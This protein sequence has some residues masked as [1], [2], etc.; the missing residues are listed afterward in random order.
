M[1]HYH[2]T[3]QA[4]DNAIGDMMIGTAPISLIADD[5]ES[6][7]KRAREILKRPH[8]RTAGVVECFD[9]H[10]HNQKVFRFMQKNNQNRPGMMPWDLDDD[11][12]EVMDDE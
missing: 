10:E 4:F 12:G 11:D 1:L 9:D 7:V 3:I 6:A 8:Y 2:W 5:E